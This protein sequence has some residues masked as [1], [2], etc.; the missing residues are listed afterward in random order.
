[1]TFSVRL[2][3]SERQRRERK[4][5]MTGNM[6]KNGRKDKILMHNN[7]RTNANQTDT[8]HAMKDALSDSKRAPFEGRKAVFY[9]SKGCLTDRKTMS[10]GLFL[11]LYS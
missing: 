10:F 4:G 6:A 5:G 9:A 1:M 11:T 2:T 7:L 8:A 3:P